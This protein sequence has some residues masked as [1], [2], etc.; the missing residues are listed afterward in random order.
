[1]TFDERIASI[2]YTV[3]IPVIAKYLGQIGLMVALLCVPPL[4]VSLLFGEHAFSLR[5]IAVIGV[6][7]VT[8]LPLIRLPAPDQIQINEG[9]SITAL[10]F[11]LTPLLMTYPLMAAGLGFQDA[12]FEA[13]SAV[14]TTGLSTLTDIENLPRTFLFARAWM[15]WFGGLGIVVLSVSLLTPMF[16]AYLND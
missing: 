7:L 5:F 15:Q 6:L 2:S 16:Y 9:L 3:R 11:A 1:M 4:L 12:L 10:T 8:S 14:T 13:I